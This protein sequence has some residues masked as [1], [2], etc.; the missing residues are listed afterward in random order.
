[1]K[2]KK[3]RRLDI[4]DKTLESWQE[5][6]DIIAG[7]AGIPAALIMRLSGPDIEVLL[8]SEGGDN[9][10]HP[11]DR[12][13]FEGSGLYC[14]TVI[15]T[16]GKLLVPNA[17]ADPDWS[18]NPDIKL[19]MISYLGFPISLPDGRPFGTICVLD[20]RENPY[21]AKI[22]RL[23]EK[24]RDLVEAELGL[25]FL[26]H[27]LGDRNREL[28]DYLGELQALR[29]LNSICSHCKSIRDGSG[30]W[31]PIEQYLIRHP[32]AEFSHGLC[33]E[34]LEKHYPSY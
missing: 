18:S 30:E 14:E 3:K 20:K 19:G 28:S 12:E 21:S 25:L 7:I 31:Q 26:N 2:L 29:G 15:K 10:Y 11:G 13:K 32:D 24:F 34:C 22:E 16:G 1:M 6:V 8:A 4:P 33:P 5:I 17:P 23:L 9:P 27:A